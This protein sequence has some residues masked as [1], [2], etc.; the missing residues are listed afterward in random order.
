MLYDDEERGNDETLI[1]RSIKHYFYWILPYEMEMTQSHDD[2]GKKR[3][4]LFYFLG[5]P[6]IHLCISFSYSHEHP[7]RKALSQEAK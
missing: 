5:S 2:E 7:K 3:V 6:F 4:S 1:T